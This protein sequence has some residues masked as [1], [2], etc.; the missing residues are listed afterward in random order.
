LVYGLLWAAVIIWWMSHRELARDDSELDAD[1]FERK[2]KWTRF[3]YF[4]KRPPWAKMESDLRRSREL[5]RLEEVT[6]AEASEL[7]YLSLK[8]PYFRIINSPFYVLRHWLR[9]G[10]WY[11]YALFLI[12]TG[13]TIALTVTAGNQAD[14]VLHGKIY[15]GNQSGAFAYHAE[16]VYVRSA[17][18]DTAKSVQQL[19]GKRL[20]LLGENAQYVILYSPDL[21]ST[22]RVPVN[23][24]VVISSPSGS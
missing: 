22:I 4:G 10:I 8:S 6:P 19:I 3:I 12:I 20:F 21:R 5:H 11:V 24:V 2:L 18:T 15:Y 23:A 13:V 17:S 1:Q 16:V 7:E 9:P 14:T